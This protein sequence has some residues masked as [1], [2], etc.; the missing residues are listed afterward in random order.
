[1]KL[2][3]Y[4]IKSHSLRRHLDTIRR[5]RCYYALLYSLQHS[6][7]SKNLFRL[8]SFHLL[9]NRFITL[10]SPSLLPTSSLIHPFIKIKVRVN[11]TLQQAVEAQSGSSY[12]FFNL[13]ARWNC[14]FKPR[15]GSFTREN[16]I[17]YPF[18]R[19]LGRPQGLSVRERRNLPLLGFDPRNV[20]PVAISYSD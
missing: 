19:R 2:H 7:Y 6:T 20:Q 10:T 4:G 17:R 16:E 15:Y 5:A 9:Q 8:G 13:G 1:M 14:V 11:F 3:F 12:S 18:Y